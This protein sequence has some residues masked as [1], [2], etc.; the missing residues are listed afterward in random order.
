[1]RPMIEAIVRDFR[2]IPATEIAATFHNTLAAL[3]VEVCAKFENRYLNRVCLSGG[4][5]QNIFLLQRAV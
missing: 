1:M 3:I 5:F 4:T 2:R